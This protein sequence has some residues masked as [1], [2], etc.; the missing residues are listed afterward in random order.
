MDVIFDKYVRSAME[1]VFSYHLQKEFCKYFISV[2]FTASN[3]QIEWD[4][5]R[6]KT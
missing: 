4:I 6:L 3:V 1:K 2:T 5:Y